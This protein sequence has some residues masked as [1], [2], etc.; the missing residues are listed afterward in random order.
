MDIGFLLKLCY[1]GHGYFS[2]LSCTAKIL[3]AAWFTQQEYIYP[4]FWK[5]QVSHQGANIVRIE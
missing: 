3:K 1:I 4:R 5:L 2:R